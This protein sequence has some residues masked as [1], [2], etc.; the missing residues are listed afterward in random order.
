VGTPAALGVILNLHVKFASLQVVCLDELDEMLNQGSNKRINTILSSI[1]Q[2]RGEFQIQTLAFSC[3]FSNEAIS[4]CSRYQQE[5][6]E[7]FD[8]LAIKSYVYHAL[9]N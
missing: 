3:E 6:F 4:L 7:S 2:Q 1:K 5:N 9:S 8:I